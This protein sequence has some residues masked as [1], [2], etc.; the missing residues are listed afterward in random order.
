MAIDRTKLA[1][2]VAVL[3]IAGAGFAYLHETP[4]PRAAPPPIKVTL[5][6]VPA[7]APQ[8]VV[9]PVPS[10]QL[11]QKPPAQ[12][13]KPKAA[14]KHTPTRA[15]AKAEP[16]ARAPKAKEP[17]TEVP[18]RQQAR[19]AKVPGQAYTHD[20]ATVIDFARPRISD[21]ALENL[22]WCIGAA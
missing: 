5:P 18:R 9:V 17:K 21:A 20:P 3:G 4:A 13:D 8:I 15:K 6:P 11:D 22:K 10:K 1:I 14:V 19:C 12:P 7:P 16:N 2:W